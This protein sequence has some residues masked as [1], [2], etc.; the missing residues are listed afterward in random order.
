MQTSAH[1]D[2]CIPVSGIQNKNN[3]ADNIPPKNM[4]SAL[5]FNLSKKMMS[6]LVFDLSN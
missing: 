4:M 1:T 6:A 3:V 5:V 2:I